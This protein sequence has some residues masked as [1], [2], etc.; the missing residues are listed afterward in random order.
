MNWLNQ[1]F[2]H[3]RHYDELFASIREHRDEE[4]ADLM[5]RGMARGQPVQA[6]RREFGNV[7][8]IEERGR[9][10]WQWHTVESIWTDARFSA[11]PSRLVLHWGW[12]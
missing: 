5:D 3:R 11:S 8:R 7:T 1:A 2:T 9:E 6:A 12:E 4:F 10:V